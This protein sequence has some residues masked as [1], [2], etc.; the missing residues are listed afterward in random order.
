MVI[1]YATI[2]NEYVLCKSFWLD[3]FWNTLSISV[4]FH[5]NPLREK[6]KRKVLILK[7]S[8]LSFYMNYNLEAISKRFLPNLHLPFLFSLDLFIILGNISSLPILSEFWLLLEIWIKLFS[9][10]Y[11]YPI[12]LITIYWKECPFSTACIF[13]KTFHQSVLL[14]HFLLL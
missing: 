7:K 12:I 10:S 11:T 3:I 6:L 8:K 2:E 13:K 14:I 1:C 4:L 9:F 5:F